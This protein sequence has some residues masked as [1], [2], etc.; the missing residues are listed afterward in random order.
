MSLSPNVTE[1]LTASGPST[2]LLPF[3]VLRLSPRG[4]EPAAS[5]CLDEHQLRTDC[6]SRAGPRHHDRSQSSFLRDQLEMLGMATLVIPGQSLAECSKRLRRSV[7]PSAGKSR[8]KSW[9]Q[10]PAVL[11]D[12][13]KKNLEPCSTSVSPG[14]GSL[15]G[16]LRDIYVATEG[17]CSRDRHH[18]GKGTITPPAS[19]PTRK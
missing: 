10:S 7:Q 13:R 2:A 12:V 15:P 14:G 16:L 4:G 5:R 17:L 1:I 11:D 19:F 18:R 9:R 6:R 8:L 3:Q